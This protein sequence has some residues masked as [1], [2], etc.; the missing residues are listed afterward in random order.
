MLSLYSLRRGGGGGGGG[1]LAAVA[2]AEAAETLSMILPALYVSGRAAALNVAA[3]TEHNIHYILNC[4]K[5]N[6]PVRTEVF[7]YK[8]LPLDDDVNQNIVQY[9][10]EA[11]AFIGRSRSAHYAR[12]LSATS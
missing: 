11:F 8:Q 3:L 12:S 4:S 7:H 6:L 9:F 10:G 1:A 2:R 5:T